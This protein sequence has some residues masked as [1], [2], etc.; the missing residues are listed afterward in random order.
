MDSCI[1]VASFERTPQMA[2]R[3]CHFHVATELESYAISDVTKN[4][5]M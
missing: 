2:T 3:T 1:S 5:G 4:K